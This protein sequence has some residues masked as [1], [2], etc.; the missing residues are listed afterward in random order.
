[1]LI[2]IKNG[3]VEINKASQMTKMAEQITASLYSEMKM[4]QLQI[5]AGAQHYAMGQLPLGEDS[6]SQVIEM[7]NKTDKGNSA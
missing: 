1:M 7:E 4:Q 5:Q 2:G 3:D 6:E